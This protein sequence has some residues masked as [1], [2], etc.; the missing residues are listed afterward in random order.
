M[1][2]ATTSSQEKFIHTF[3][4]FSSQENSIHNFP[5]FRS[6]LPCAVLRYLLTRLTAIE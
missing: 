1:G 4:A 6:G 3:Y 5:A 2:G